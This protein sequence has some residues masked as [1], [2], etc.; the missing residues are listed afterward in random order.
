MKWKNIFRQLAKERTFFFNETDFALELG[1]LLAK[2]RYGVSFEH[3]IIYDWNSKRI[4]ILAI[5]HQSGRVIPIELKYKTDADTLGSHPPLKYRNVR[6]YPKRN[7]RIDVYLKDI[8]IMGKVIN[9]RDIVDYNEKKIEIDY[10]YCIILSNNKTVINSLRYK[11]DYVKWLKYDSK[12][13]TSF[14]T[15]YYTVARIEKNKK[16]GTIQKLEWSNYDM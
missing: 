5:E 12:D 4:D 3:R 10:A 2:K 6:F 1:Y 9:A 11:G 7:S 15:F 8:E 14:Y 13:N 16:D